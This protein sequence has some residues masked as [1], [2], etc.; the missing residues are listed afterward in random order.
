M[1]SDFRGSILLS[2]AIYSGIIVESALVEIRMGCLNEPGYER[3]EV[4]ENNNDHAT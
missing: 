4:L 2:F 1:A 3:F